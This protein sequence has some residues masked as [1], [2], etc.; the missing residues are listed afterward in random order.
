MRYE[1]TRQRVN[2]GP[3]QSIMVETPEKAR[4]AYDLAVKAGDIFVEVFDM[5][6]DTQLYWHL[7]PAQWV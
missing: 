1:V 2:C 3:T 7:T 4:Y 5:E 6:A